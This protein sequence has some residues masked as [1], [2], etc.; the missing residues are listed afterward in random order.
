MPLRELNRSL[1]LGVILNEREKKKKAT[2][3][4]DSAERAWRYYIST[5]ETHTDTKYTKR[6]P[7]KKRNYRL[8]YQV[9]WINKRM[10]IRFVINYIYIFQYFNYLLNVNYIHIII[11]IIY[12]YYIYI[13]YTYTPLMR[14][15]P[16]VK[17]WRRVRRRK[18]PRGESLRERWGRKWKW[19]NLRRITRETEILGRTVG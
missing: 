7:K 13:L 6:D 14:A 5:D 10:I 17:G 16:R 8:F 19:W 3:H 4:F 18:Q 9:K 1:S 2:L 15:M 12:I 11:Y